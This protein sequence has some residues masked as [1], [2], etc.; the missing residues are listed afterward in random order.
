SPPAV[1]FR[2][3][4]S[5]GRLGVLAG[6]RLGVPCGP[7]GV[8]VRLIPSGG[9]GGS[10]RGGRPV[11]AGVRSEPGGF[12]PQRRLECGSARRRRIVVQ[13]GGLV[14]TSGAG[15]RTRTV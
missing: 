10:V 5:T 1:G 11:V 2:V 15:G 8:S 14:V 4:P 7:G 3:G 12:P 9:E 6:V 13:A